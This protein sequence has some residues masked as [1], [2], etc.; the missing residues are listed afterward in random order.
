MERD[1]LEDENGTFPAMHEDGEQGERDGRD[2]D[3]QDYEND[4]Q[5]D[6]HDLDREMPSYRAREH[7]YGGPT[8]FAFHSRSYDDEDEALQAALKASMDDLPP[9]WVAPPAEPK[10]QVNKKVPKKAAPVLE[11]V[12]TEAVAQRPAI[13]SPGVGGSKFKE[14]IEDDDDVQEVLSPSELTNSLSCTM[15]TRSL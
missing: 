6:E 3:E 5:L 13:E 10:E 14:E 1:V 15:L 4:E 11:P 7:T 2:G 9:D 8:D 12:V